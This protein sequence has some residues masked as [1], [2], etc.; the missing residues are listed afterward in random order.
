MFYCQE[1]KSEFLFICF[2]YCNLMIPLSTIQTNNLGN[3]SATA[4]DSNGVIAS[5]DWELKWFGNI[6]QVF[7]R[8]AHAQHKISYILDMLMVWLLYQYNHTDPCTTAFLDSFIM[9]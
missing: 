5:R 4:H 3:I 9:Q 8:D 6:V 1:Q 7:I 2:A